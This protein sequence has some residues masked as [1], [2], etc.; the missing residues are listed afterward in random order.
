M[1]IHTWGTV[2]N[3]LCKASSVMEM[4]FYHGVSLALSCS[5][6]EYFFH[7]SAPTKSSVFPLSEGVR[8]WYL[9]LQFINVRHF[10]KI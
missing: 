9:C 1:S 7:F 10:T 2:G 5:T 6:F 4:V 8:A 3:K